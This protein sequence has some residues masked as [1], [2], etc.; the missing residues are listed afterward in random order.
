VVKLLEGN[1]IYRIVNE[2]LT[3]MQPYLYGW[4]HNTPSVWRKFW[5][6]WDRLCIKQPIGKVWLVF[7]IICTA[8]FSI[9]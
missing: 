2:T 6:F 9:Y 1:S 5:N 8:F 3:K 7:I 4:R